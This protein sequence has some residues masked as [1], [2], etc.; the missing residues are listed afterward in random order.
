METPIILLII[1][2]AIIGVAVV[3]W[4]IMR[5]KRSEALKHRFG[6]EYERAIRAAGNKTSA[7]AELLARTKR[8][9]KLDIH[10]LSAGDR[11]RFADRWRHAQASFVDNPAGAVAEADALVDEIMR[12]RGYPV[13][14]FERRAADISV[15]H[16]RV[17]QNY[18]DAR[19]IAMSA[20]RG[21]ARTEDLR[22]ATLFYRELFEDLLETASRTMAE[23]PR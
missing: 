10:P 11:D 13:A 15:D 22:R 6:D 12:A 4:T 23:V 20:Q 21:T 18:R 14:D 17:V 9:E 19:A 5:T 2:V 16:P 8:V 1:A 3:A 7:E